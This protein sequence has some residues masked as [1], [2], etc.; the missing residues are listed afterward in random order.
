MLASAG[1]SPDA[2]TQQLA[3]RPW[4][5]QSAGISTKPAAWAMESCGLIDAQQLYPPSH[6]L[7]SRYLDAHRPLA[8][9]QILI[10]SQR[11]SD[12]LNA[13]LVD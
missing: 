11:L 1:V 3:A 2:Y 10:A 8:E 5:P 6:K 4:P 12:L 7:D 13:T 9:R